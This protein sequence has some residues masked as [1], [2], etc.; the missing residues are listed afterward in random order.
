[1]DKADQIEAVADWM[2][3]GPRAAFRVAET[4]L[5]EMGLVTPG[6]Q[7]LTFGLSVALF[8]LVLGVLARRSAPR[9]ASVTR[10]PVTAGRMAAARPLSRRG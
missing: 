8:A 2:A 7:A 3:D 6:A 4:F 1:M 5:G 9:G 10:V